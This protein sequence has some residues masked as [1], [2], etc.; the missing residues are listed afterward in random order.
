VRGAMIGRNVLYPADGDPLEPA[1]AIRSLVHDQADLET[2]LAC[3][4]KAAV[5]PQDV[6]TRWL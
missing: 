3:M 1:Y 4:E 2:A 6:L 5:V